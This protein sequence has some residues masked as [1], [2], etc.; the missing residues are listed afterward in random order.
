LLRYRPGQI[1]DYPITSTEAQLDKLMN[2]EPVLDQDVV[3]WYGAHFTHD[4]RGGDH[5]SGIGHVIGPDLVPV[6]W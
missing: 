3:V 2:R 5:H 6:N 1:D 4:V